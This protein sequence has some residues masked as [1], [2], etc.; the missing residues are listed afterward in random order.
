MLNHPSFFTDPWQDR[1]HTFGMS[2]RDKKKIMAKIFTWIVYWCTVWK[3][4]SGAV[5]PLQRRR[6]FYEYPTMF[7]NVPGVLAWVVFIAIVQ[8]FLWDLH[9]NFWSRQLSVIGEIPVV[10]WILTMGQNIGVPVCMAMISQMAN[11]GRE[12]HSCIFIFNDRNIHTSGNIL[13]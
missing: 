4:L 9:R 12:W 11:R 10:W 8:E 3:E 6:N 7:H 13:C 5:E 1:Y 2:K